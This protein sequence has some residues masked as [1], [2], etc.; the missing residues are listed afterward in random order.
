MILKDSHLKAIARAQHFM[1]SGITQ[2]MQIRHREQ[3]ERDIAL[4]DSIHTYVRQQINEPGLP[5]A[6]IPDKILKVGESI[7]N[8]NTVPAD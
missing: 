5:L 8:E 2:A 1:R 4:L 7:G 3:V 6:P